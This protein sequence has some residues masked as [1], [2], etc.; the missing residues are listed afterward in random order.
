MGQII[1]PYLS[2]FDKA[3]KEDSSQNYSLT[4]R[5]STDGFCF[6]IF[7]PEKNRFL[8]LEHFRFQDFDNEDRICRALDEIGMFRQWLSFPFKTVSMLIDHPYHALI[9]SP[10]YDEKARETYLS[11]NQQYREDS[12]ILH[13]QLITAQ[14]HN[15]FYLS[16]R[17]HA[18]IKEM[19]A[20]AHIIHS[21][22][23][24]IESILIA[25][26]NLGDD[27]KVFI[28]FAK[29][30]FEL[31]WVKQL[32]LG[33]FNRFRFHKPEDFIY[34]I[35]Y[36]LDQLKLSPESIEL[37]ISGDIESGSNYL[38]ICSTY[39]R[40]IR[41]AARNTAFEYSYVLED[42]PSHKYL[43]LYNRLLCEL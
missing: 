19:W 21:S 26:R 1:K 43:N 12:K 18:K 32:R 33:F 4:I 35:L 34:F 28:Q 5:L 13:D 10:L 17:L 30:S 11:F 37:I 39:I 7:D 36:S 14:A 20:N 40:T 22:S 42:I 16:K 2:R 25:S 29:N 27:N 23:A 15:I 24:F 8:G 9:P 6:V 41:F 31:L 3:F 38:D